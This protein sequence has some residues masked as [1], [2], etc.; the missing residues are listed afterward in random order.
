M[1]DLKFYSQLLTSYNNAIGEIYIEQKLSQH[2]AR[3]L[4]K[5]KITYKDD[6]IGIDCE[7]EYNPID[8]ICLYLMDYLIYFDMMEKYYKKEKRLMNSKIYKA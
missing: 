4:S 3:I 8:E 7:Y 6:V 1:F 2:Q 5:D